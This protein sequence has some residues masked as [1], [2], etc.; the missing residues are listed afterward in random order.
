MSCEKCGRAKGHE[1]VGCKKVFETIQNLAQ[2]VRADSVCAG[3]PHLGRGK[4]AVK[5]T[6]KVIEHKRQR[7]DESASAEGSRS[8]I[9]ADDSEDSFE[10]RL[11]A[12]KSGD[13]EKK[14]KRNV[15]LAAAAT[16]EQQSAVIGREPMPSRKERQKRAL[17]VA[18]AT[19]ATKR[20]VMDVAKRLHRVGVHPQASSASVAS[21]EEDDDDEDTD[22]KLELNKHRKGSRRPA[23]P[24]NAVDAARPAKTRS[25]SSAPVATTSTPTAPSR[26]KTP[27]STGKRKANNRRWGV[28]EFLW[29]SLAKPND[30]VYV[31]ALCDKSMPLSKHTQKNFTGKNGHCGQSH[32][33]LVAVIKEVKDKRGTRNVAREALVRWLQTNEASCARAAPSRPTASTARPIVQHVLE[34]YLPNS[35]TALAGLETAGSSTRDHLLVHLRA[36]QLKAHAVEASLGT[37]LTSV[38]FACAFIDAGIPL[39]VMDSPAMRAACEIAGNFLLPSATVMRRYGTLIAAANDEWQKVASSRTDTI[40]HI[41][42]DKWSH[43]NESF[44]GICGH[45]VDDDYN[46]RTHLIDLVPVDAGEQSGDAIA[47]LVRGALDRGLDANVSV[48]A[49]TTDNAKSEL[50]AA[51]KLSGGYPQHCW[52]HLGSLAEKTTI[53]RLVEAEK[54]PTLM[55]AIDKA[56]GEAKF[57]RGRNMRDALKRA[58][59]ELDPQL[60][61]QNAKMF[62]IPSDTRWHSQLACLQACRDTQLRAAF[63][64]VL[65]E[66]VY[67]KE[68]RDKE[69]P[70]LNA[71]ER[72][73]VDELIKVLELY[74]VLM[75]TVETTDSIVSHRVAGLVYDY[76]E[77]LSREKSNEEWG[78]DTR[79]FCGVFE[80]QLRQRFGPVFSPDAT[81]WVAMAAA[82]SPLTS[83]FAWCEQTVEWRTRMAVA[84]CNTKR[85]MRQ[86]ENSNEREDAEPRRDGLEQDAA[87]GRLLADQSSSDEDVDEQRIAEDGLKALQRWAALVSEPLAFEHSVALRKSVLAVAE[88]P[89]KFWWAVW[90]RGLERMINAEA[91]L[92][93]N[94][95]A[96]LLR[97]LKRIQTFEEHFRLAFRCVY[98]VVPSSAMVERVFSVAKFL[99][100]GRHNED[101]Q[102]FRERL[103]VRFEMQRRLKSVPQEERTTRRDCDEMRKFMVDMTEK[104]RKLRERPAQQNED[105]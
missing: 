4:R 97:H 18:S 75:R 26:T 9:G 46:H 61:P 16:F 89:L 98:S 40:V 85:E 38:A 84:L 29:D 72:L 103:L 13:T 17:G 100:R 15:E 71:Q 22:D 58:Q 30:K 51:A 66:N 25:P 82:V 35:T 63:D 68:T 74:R 53:A 59:C 28:G 92:D 83:R 48:V 37:N 27:P 88:E 91:K 14:N 41:S 77:Y 57:V 47:T 69:A 105:Q 52:A 96:A 55:R 93:E 7:A 43:E 49:S 44:I 24:P 31:C 86:M 70:A 90:H 33:A 64:R 78:R 39:R 32:P 76:I 23:A 87:L 50:I 3:D 42:F 45:S 99:K 94:V 73:A 54:A 11:A 12:K 36:E 81:S 6:A 101:P 79:E 67:I 95:K 5:P 62:K 102:T 10:P 60:K 19:E 65:E 20:R 34:E 8:A 1:C 2:H 104:C 56:V 21:E 80:R